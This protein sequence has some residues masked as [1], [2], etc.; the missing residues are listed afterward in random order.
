MEIL[1]VK[2]LNLTIDG[3]LKV[4]D[5]SFTIHPGDVALLTGPNG[6]GKSTFVKL[7]LGATFEYKDLNIENTTILYKETHD[8]LNSETD[9]EAFRRKVCYVSQEDEFETESV[10]DCF[11]NSIDY[12]VKDNKARFVFD[13]IKQFSIQECFGISPENTKL[14]RRGRRILR[15]LG[16]PKR[17]LTNTDIKAIKLL[18]MNTKRMSGGQRKLANIFSNLIRYAFCDLIILDEPLNNLDYNNVR[19]FSNVLTKIYHTKP[20]LAIILV[21]HCRSIPIVNRVITFDPLRKEL[22][23]DESYVCSSC[24]GSVDKDSLYQA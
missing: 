10:L 13:F 18:A 8:I 14:D 5:G 19:A 16:L 4:K 9:N 6:C 24:F 20:E 22:R 11:I 2:Q 1:C 3:D 23:E 12:A 17:E 7:L 21:T 15:L